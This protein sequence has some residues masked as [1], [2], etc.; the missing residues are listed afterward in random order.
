MDVYIAKTPDTEEKIMKK[1]K[2][3]IIRILACG[4]I[5]A[6]LFGA[7]ACSSNKGTAVVKKD[8]RI[9]DSN[10]LSGDVHSYTADI[11]NE[12]AD[13]ND[14][15]ETVAADAEQGI[16]ENAGG[17]AAANTNVTATTTSQKL[18][19]TV[20]MSVET[21]KFDEVVNS[22]KSKVAQT[23]GYIQVSDISGTGKNKSFKHGRF[24]LRI[25]ADKADSVISTLG[26]NVTVISSSESTED[27]TLKYSDMQSH[28]DS[29]KIEREALNKML[30]NATELETIIRL[31]E[32]IT[33]IRYEIENY[34][35]TLKVLDNQVTYTTINLD[36][37]EVV[38]EREVEEIKKLTTGEEMA[39]RFNENLEDVKEG[40]KDFAIGFV[41]ALPYLFVLLGVCLI[42]ALVIFIIFKIVKS[43]HNRKQKARDKKKALSDTSSA[44]KKS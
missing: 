21:V 37:D 27:V 44:D 41:A 30:E 16:S 11:E 34:Q 29:L 42:I 25:P 17:N 32:R 2:D 5:F 10:S 3:T 40:L 9:A 1:F 19:R 35:S 12:A 13:M 14:M 36:I 39:K 28:I 22:I 24:I 23:G 7:V 4:A 43:S 26:D 31:Q 18:I 20:N 38:E 6:V 15:Q 33:Q 8:A